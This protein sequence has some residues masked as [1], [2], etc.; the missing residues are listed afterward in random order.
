MKSI[1]IT[2][3][4]SPTAAVR[5]YAKIPDWQ[6][7]VVGDRKT[8][9]GWECAGVQY[10]GCQTQEESPLELSRVLPWNHYCRKMLGYLSA[11]HQG[12]EVIVDTD[13]DNLP[14]ENWG[15]GAFDATFPMTE[16][17]RG[18]V[19]VYSCFSD[20]Y[21][22]P[23]GFPLR[24]LREASLDW[25]G[26]REQP[27]R[28]GV[29][30][31]LVDADPDVDAIYRLV[32]DKPVF[33]NSR[34]PVVLAEGT[35]CPFNSQ[36]TAYREELFALLY[37]PCHVT[38]RFTDILRGLVAQP[39]MWAAGFRLGFTEA[40]VLQERNPHDY[41][42]D[43]KSEIPCYVHAD[44]IIALT[45]SVVR[46]TASVEDNLYA[47]YQELHRAKIVHEEELRCVSAWLSDLR[48]ARQR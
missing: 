23:R 12:A 7:V 39:I 11:I 27:V 4:A 47:A 36:N 26:L 8:P 45:R 24:Q 6:T 41:L 5:A 13:D 32:F 43:F 20:Q 19:N 2:S 22:W 25:N 17:D 40:T 31:G 37:L 3:I 18:F 21:V 16:P 30:Q 14:K 34:P 1:V 10:L 33:F 48:E 44:D 42:E 46:P 9:A 15:F 29:W 28:V 35:A 38:F